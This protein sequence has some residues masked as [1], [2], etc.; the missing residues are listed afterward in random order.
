MKILSQAR[1]FSGTQAVY[2]HTSDTCQ[3]EMQFAVFTPSERKHGKGPF[4]VLYWLSGLTCTEENF[5]AKAGAQRVAAELGLIV[6]ASDTSPRGEGVPD[7]PD[8][9]YD[10]GLGAGFYLNATEEPWA[11]NYNMGD[12]ITEELPALI[13]KEFSVDPTRAGIFG[14]SMG[15]HGALT[16]HLK[17]QKK[18]KSCSA[19]APIVAPSSVPWGRK[20]FSHYLGSDERRWAPYDAVALLND[21]GTSDAHIL[22]DQGTADNFLQEQLKPELFKAAADEAGQ[23]LTLRMQDG[24]DHSYYFIST[25]MEDHLRWHA[26]QLAL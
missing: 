12:Y 19:F 11:A 14:H 5:I 4:P 10:F 3:C 20:A 9:A 25:F 22:I 17:N 15:G 8:G 21:H 6:V 13:E 26:K 2:A 16:I 24:Y 1:S 7:D 23:A 18:F